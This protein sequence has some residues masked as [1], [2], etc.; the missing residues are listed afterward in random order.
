[1]PKIRLLIALGII[2][3]FGTRLAILERLRTFQ[4]MPIPFSVVT[5]SIVFTAASMI[6]STII[7]IKRI[8]VGFD[9]SAPPPE[10]A[11]LT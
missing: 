1:M 6:I 10:Q 5:A 11:G 2:A 9:D 3:Y 8:L 7:K 4:S